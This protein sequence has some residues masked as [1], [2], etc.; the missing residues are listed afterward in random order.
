MEEK[1]FLKQ[2]GYNIRRLRMKKGLS[3]LDLASVCGFEK[4]SIGRIENGN[5]NPTAKTLLKIAKALNV[6]VTELVKTTTL[7]QKPL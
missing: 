4:S 5:T 6:R 1:K 7:P 3:Q 2:I